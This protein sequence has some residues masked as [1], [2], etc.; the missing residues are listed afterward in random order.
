MDGFQ[1]DSSASVMDSLPVFKASILDGLGLDP[2]QRAA[3]ENHLEQTGWP[4]LFESIE[5]MRTS[6][7]ISRTWSSIDDIV[8]LTLP[9]VC[10]L[11][12]T[13]VDEAF[14]PGR[15]PEECKNRRR[16][17]ADVGLEELLGEIPNVSP[18]FSALG[19]KGS[20]DEMLRIHQLHV[21]RKD[22][23]TSLRDIV[24]KQGS[25]SLNMSAPEMFRSR[26]ALN[27][28]GWPTRFRSVQT[29]QT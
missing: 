22:A 1:D 9:Q 15:F 18:N 27:E 8:L 2:Q 23:I 3:L 25:K 4:T 24:L 29:Y 5:K 21:A 16:T 12:L 7:K 26:D 20:L 14:F 6:F 13:L 11:D 17:L 19:D 10:D 28:E